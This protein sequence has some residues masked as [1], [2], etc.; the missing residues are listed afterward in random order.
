MAEGEEE[1]YAHWPLPLLHQLT[2]HIVDCGDMIGI[3][4]VTQA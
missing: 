3:D 2:G 1:T 4:R